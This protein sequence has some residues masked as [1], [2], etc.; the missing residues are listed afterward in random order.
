MIKWLKNVWKNLIGPETAYWENLGAPK[1]TKLKIPEREEIL[2]KQGFVWE[3]YE[4]GVPIGY[5]K[6]PSRVA[7]ARKDLHRSKLYY[8]CNKYGTYEDEKYKLV[9][10]KF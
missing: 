5:Y 7:A 4:N 6:N 8:H 9:C 3:L 1:P 2:K 10:L